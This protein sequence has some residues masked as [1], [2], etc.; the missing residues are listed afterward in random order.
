[1]SSK[2]NCSDAIDT[3]NSYLALRGGGREFDRYNFG[4]KVKFPEHEGDN[5]LFL[6][7]YDTFNP[8]YPMKTIRKTF[9][10][11]REEFE[12]LVNYDGRRGLNFRNSGRLKTKLQYH[13]FK[14]TKKDDSST[15]IVINESEH[16]ELRR[17]IANVFEDISIMGPFLKPAKDE[18]VLI[19]NRVVLIRLFKAHI[20][21]EYEKIFDPLA[22]NDSASK[23]V[24]SVNKSTFEN[25][26]R[27][28]RMVMDSTIRMEDITGPEHLAIF[29]VMN[30]EMFP[31][32][33]W[34]IH[35]AHCTNFANTNQKPIVSEEKIM[36]PTIIKTTYSLRKNNKT[37]LRLDVVF[38]NGSITPEFILQREFSCERGWG[39]A[40]NQRFVRMCQR[41]KLVLGKDE[42]EHLASKYPLR[43]D[44]DY[45]NIQ[46]RVLDRHVHLIFV[47]QSVGDR[48]HAELIISHSEELWL[49][50]TGGEILEDLDLMHPYINKKKDLHT[51]VNSRYALA[52]LVTAYTCS[53]WEH[54]KNIPDNEKMINVLKDVRIPTFE[55]FLHRNGLTIDLRDGRGVEENGKEFDIP[56]GEM[57]LSQ[58]HPTREIFVEGGCLDIMKRENN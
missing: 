9:F 25:F 29:S 1:M 10:F 7:D 41:A 19:S 48:D 13:S 50:K 38:R 56:M 24:K 21:D 3:D 35:N 20:R 6:V 45:D 5:H 26:L 55:T 33:S 23:A 22:P 8:H 54:L 4:I 30:D 40:S 17:L 49:Q 39:H 12:Q 43:R 31:T 53:I 34:F 51:T 37:Q 27:Q 47:D 57:G 15:S 46:T 44:C 32:T 52:R 11:T 28:N 36:C 42:M 14:L 16:D 18:L 2:R 58:C